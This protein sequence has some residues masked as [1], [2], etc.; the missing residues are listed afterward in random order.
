MRGGPEL[1][2][3]WPRS[4]T[5]V[6][7]ACAT[8]LCHSASA[9]CA[10]RAAAPPS[11]RN[12]KSSERLTEKGLVG[13][14]QRL[15]HAPNSCSREREREAVIGAGSGVHSSVIIAGFVGRPCV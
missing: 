9:A 4:P 5:T 12:A 10:P 7:W 6:L 15:V 11:C 3:L 14:Q 2:R 1:R 13:S 8:D